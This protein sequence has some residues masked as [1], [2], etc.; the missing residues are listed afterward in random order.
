[1]NIFTTQAEPGSDAFG[2]ELLAAHKNGFEY[3]QSEDTKQVF[4]I[5]EDEDSIGAEPLCP[6]HTLD[7][8]EDNY[9]DGVPDDVLSDEV[10]QFLAAEKKPPITDADALADLYGYPRPD[11]PSAD[12]VEPES[13]PTH[14]EMGADIATKIDSIILDRLN[15]DKVIDG[16]SANVLLKLNEISLSRRV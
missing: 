13:N 4:A 11:N 12:A 9:P 7:V 5:V 14:L 1:M 16:E 10:L 2:M 15:T 3:G 6:A 8:L